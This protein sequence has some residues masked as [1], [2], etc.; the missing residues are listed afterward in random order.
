MEI[1]LKAS[2]IY[3]AAGTKKLKVRKIKKNLNC[4]SIEFAQTMAKIMAI[5]LG[6]QCK[7]ITGVI[8]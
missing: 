7:E 4:L 2:G 8:K 3:F 5:R 6:S 1:S